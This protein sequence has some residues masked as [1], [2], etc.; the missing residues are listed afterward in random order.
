MGTEIYRMLGACGVAPA[1]N[2]SH[3]ISDA[4]RAPIAAG[5]VNRIGRGAYL[6]GGRP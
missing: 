1:G 4:L 5:I 2:P 3:D 6:A